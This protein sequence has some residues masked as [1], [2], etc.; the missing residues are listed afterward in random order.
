MAN[1]ET[2]KM[3]DE[4]G[5]MLE[6]VKGSL[7]STEGFILEQAP[8]YAQELL[9]YEFATSLFWGILLSIPFLVMILGSAI[10]AYA[11]MKTDPE[12]DIVKRIDCGGL[13]GV[14]FIVGV[15]RMA[16]S[17]DLLNMGVIF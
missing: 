12:E 14:F 8:L 4:L 17:V 13:C 3:Q 2:N 7:E 9:A 1:E 11:F 15:I 5:N 10:S 16:R 6:W